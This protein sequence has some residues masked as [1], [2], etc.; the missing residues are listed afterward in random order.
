MGH[1]VKKK[2]VLLHD[3]NHLLIH[4]VN[5]NAHVLCG[6]LSKAI[7]TSLIN[8]FGTKIS[9]LNAKLSQGV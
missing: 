8:P 4:L 2:I 9:L 1:F 5:S 7:P 3:I 6:Y